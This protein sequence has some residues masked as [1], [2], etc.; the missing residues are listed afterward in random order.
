L[1]TS[2]YHDLSDTQRAAHLVFWY[3]HEVQNGGHLQYFENRGTGQV[4]QVI[5]ALKRLG[6]D[7]QAEVL[8]RAAAQFAAKVRTK[9][10]S[11][12]EYVETALQGEFDLFDQE[13]CACRPSLVKALEAFLKH[14]QFAFVVIVD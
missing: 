7:C 11:V 9:I 10:E 3:E 6:A 1:A 12:E 13:F 5:D 2:D 4:G 8:F 14:N